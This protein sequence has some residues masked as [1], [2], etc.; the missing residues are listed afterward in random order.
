METAYRILLDDLTVSSNYPGNKEHIPVEKLIKDHDFV[1]L[2]ANRWAH[3][4]SEAVFKSSYEPNLFHYI[5]DP[6][7]HHPGTWDVEWTNKHL[8]EDMF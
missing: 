1:R 2:D 4:V 5:I 8:L 3:Y 6:V 7:I